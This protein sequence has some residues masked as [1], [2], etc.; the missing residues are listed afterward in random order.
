M[1]RKRGKKE[2]EKERRGEEEK[3]MIVAIAAFIAY[4]FMWLPPAATLVLGPATNG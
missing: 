3:F 1:K 4:E 2:K